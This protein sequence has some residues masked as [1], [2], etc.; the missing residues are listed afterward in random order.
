[1]DPI[2]RRGFLSTAGAGIGAAAFAGM[3]VAHAGEDHSGLK[4]GT[5]LVELGK[6]G[7]KTTVLG[8]GTGTRGGS[9][10][11]AL[12]TEGLTKLIRHGLDRGIQY[13]DT[14]DMYM[15]H[16]YLQAALAG[17]PR[18]KYFIQSKTRAK[19]AEVAQADLDRF[20][21][22]LRCKY[23]DTCLIH[24][25]TAGD[26]P[27]TMAPVMDVLSEAKEKGRVRAC[28]VSCHS[29][30]ALT[31]A[32]ECDWVDVILVRIN[33]DGTKMDG[34]PEEVAPLIKKLHDK[35]VG[36]IGMK[37]YGEGAF[38][39]ADQRYK[40]LDYVLGLQAVDAFTIGFG[41][42]EQIDETLAM[43]DKILA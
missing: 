42:T 36:V 28:G 9:E 29:L 21:R 25:M 41:K 5:D 17:I 23:L 14:A 33:N 7:L 2:S 35:G 1:M 16:V 32:S 27:T 11:R 40:S 13:I 22:E 37:I 34:S 19:S 43:I 30:D 8:M 18:E 24:C 15:T 31:A 12:G 39:S 20:V 3:K 6:T 10:Q 26:W 38:Q 4:H